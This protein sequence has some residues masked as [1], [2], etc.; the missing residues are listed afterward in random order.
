MAVD[1]EAADVVGLVGHHEL[2]EEALQ[3]DVGER[4]LGGDVLFGIG[5]GD[6]GEHVARARRRRLRHQL[7]EVAER[8]NG[9]PPRRA[10]HGAPSVTVE[11]PQHSAKGGRSTIRNRCDF[12]DR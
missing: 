12:A 8:V 2:G 11:A 6:T 4:H 1:D 7:L 3:G 10:I 5:G 9:L